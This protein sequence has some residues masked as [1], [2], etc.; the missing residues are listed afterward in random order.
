MVGYR[1]HDLKEKEGGEDPPGYHCWELCSDAA[2]F[3][4]TFWAFFQLLLWAI[5]IISSY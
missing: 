1:V 5:C 2:F 3:A 4:Q